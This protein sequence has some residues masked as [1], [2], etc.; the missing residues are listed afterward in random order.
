MCRNFLRDMTSFI[1]ELLIR[2]MYGDR[3]SIHGVFEDEA[4]YVPQFVREM[5]VAADAIFGELDVVA[6]RGA[7]DKRQARGVGAVFFYHRERIDDVA[8]T[9]THLLSLAIAHEAVQIHL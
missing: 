3:I 5:L 2:S 9:L 8:E 4:G 1:N 6:H 7:D